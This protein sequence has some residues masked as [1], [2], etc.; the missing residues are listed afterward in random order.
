MKKVLE[1]LFTE[2]GP[3]TIY[4]T[5]KRR[6]SS[7]RYEVSD[8]AGRLSFVESSAFY[9]PE[10]NVMIQDGK[11]IGLGSRAGTLKEYEV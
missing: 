5:I 3:T 1:N 2:K 9:P 11:I 7:T 8:S 4:R 10:T 6:I